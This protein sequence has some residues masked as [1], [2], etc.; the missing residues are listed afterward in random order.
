[1]DEAQMKQSET[2]RVATTD[3]WFTV[4]VRDAAWVQ[5]EYFGD[6]CIFEGYEGAPF[7]EIGYTLCVLQPGQPN[8][9][10]HRE[11][12]QEDFLIL[13]GEAVLIVE[14]QERRLKAWDF[15]HSP[16]GTDHI[17]VGAGEGPCIVFAIGARKQGGD[18]NDTLYVRHETAL[19]HGAGPEQDT[20]DNKVAYAPFPKWVNGPPP[21]FAGLP[22]A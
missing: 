19:K 10:Y 22:F 3:G 12:N 7:A 11:D 13:Q 21:T 2:G 9:M 17:L 20:P 8:G 15:F 16:A 5:N 6:A 18:S 1:M 14:G 4:N